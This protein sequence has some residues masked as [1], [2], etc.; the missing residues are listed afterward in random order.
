MKRS[1]S[2]FRALIVLFPVLFLAAGCGG[3]VMKQVDTPTT[4]KI[5]VGA[6]DSYTLLMDAE[7]YAFHAM[8]KYSQIDTVMGT[9]ADIIDLFMKDSI[10]MMV[11]NRK[12]M[13]DEEKYLNDRQIIP[14]TTLIAYDGV[15]FIVNNANPDTNLFYDNLAAIFKGELKS[16]KQINP[17]RSAG[18]SI[19]VIFDHYRSGNPRYLREKFGL[20]KL[21][22]NCFAV[23]RNA[24]V[25]AYVEKNKN[26]IGVISVN[27]VS[28][29]ADTVSHGFLSR[30][31]VARISL[32]GTTDPASPFYTPHPGYIA[33]GSYP[34]TRE[35]YCINRQ[36]YSGLAF[37]LSAF[38]A[39]EK[40]QLIV[41]HSGLVPAA[42]PVRLVEIKH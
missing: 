4:G 31:K 28:D 3:D 39:G 42:Q 40:G 11:I 8:Y 10:P 18:D 32:P 5:R 7:L 25:I 34:F 38:I 21:P 29:K 16:W 13:K 1:N 22:S 36:T 37:G 12:L 6:D 20:E 35:V 19:R 9:E 33:T 24:E 41:L 15:A 26:A 23:E 2:L 14:K 30:V 27:W 17:K